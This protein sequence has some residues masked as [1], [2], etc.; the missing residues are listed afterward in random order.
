MNPV[1]ANVVGDVCYLVYPVRHHALHSQGFVVVFV[2]WILI[3]RLRKLA[4]EHFQDTVRIGM[5]MNGRT[6]S[7][8]PNEQELFQSSLCVSDVTYMFF[9]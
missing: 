2:S 7:G 1:K 6:F 8:V 9:G 5:V 4:R 3:D